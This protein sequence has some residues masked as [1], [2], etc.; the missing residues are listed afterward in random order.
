MTSTALARAPI[1]D[2]TPVLLTH[3]QTCGFA[4]VALSRGL[5]AG[6][7]NSAGAMISWL[8]LGR[9]GLSMRQAWDCAAYSVLR[10]QSDQDRREFT[11]R[12]ATFSLGSAAPRGVEV[13]PSLFPPTAWLTHPTLFRLIDEHFVRVLTPL[14]HLVYLTRDRQDLFVLDGN[15]REVAQQFPRATVMTYSYGFPLRHRCPDL[16]RV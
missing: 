3:P 14:H 4:S 8:D 16:T 10:T 9:M 6:V 1:T 13:G 7:A 15:P 5:S 11:V 2:F 12:N